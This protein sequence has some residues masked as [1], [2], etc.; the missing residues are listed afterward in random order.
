LAIFASLLSKKNKMVYILLFFI[1]H[2][3]LSLFG[4]TFF[5]HRYG[6]HKM[7]TMNAFW[8]KFFYTFF[9]LMQGSSYLNPRAYAILHRMHHAYSD[10]EK[11]P[12]S[13]MFFKDLFGM[14]WH[15][16]KIYF[17]IISKDFKH[18]ERFDKNYPE[19]LALDKFADSWPVR[20]AFGVLYSL[21]YIKFVPVDQHWAYAFLYLLL[22]IQFLMGPVH[23]AIVNWCGHKY[24]Y[25]N[26]NEDDHSKNTLVFDFLML[27]E[28]FQNNH[29]HFGARP[30]F[31]NKW[32]E[33]DPVYP[34]IKLF[35]WIGVIK[36][37]LSNAKY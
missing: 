8:E 35:S 15:T 13:P 11:D 6:A 3:Y 14:M 20:I 9:W 30:N 17:G 21:F 34:F 16:K 10:T 18:E 33:F 32:W 23:G 4:Q 12:H 28:L 31:A 24:G 36:L 26:H 1:G 22:P 5:Y 27:G 7:F 25:R 29:H 37:N 19:W 2:W